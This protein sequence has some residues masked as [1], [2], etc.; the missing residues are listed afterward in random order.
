MNDILFHLVIVGPIVRYLINLGY[1]YTKSKFWGLAL[2]VI[3]LGIIAYYECRRQP[4][5][6]DIL[7]IP[8]H[9]QK[10]ALTKDIKAAFKKISLKTHPDK[11]LDDPLAHD[12]YIIVKNAHEI[13]QNDVHRSNYIRFGDFHGPNDETP[14]SDDN[15]SVVMTVS[16]TQYLTLLIIGLMFSYSKEQMLARQMILL[17]L[18]AVFCLEIQMRFTKNDSTLDW[19][20]MFGD[21]LVFEKIVMFRSVFPSVLNIAMVVSSCLYTDQDSITIQLLQETITSNLKLVKH[22]VD[23]FNIVD[24]RTSAPVQVLD[25]NRGDISLVDA[26]V[27]TTPDNKPNIDWMSLTDTQKS[28]LMRNIGPNLKKEKKGIKWNYIVG[29]LIII[30]AMMYSKMIE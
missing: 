21:F 12:R 29:S 14:L 4:N 18:A 9:Q 19:V 17:Y 28:E 5:L 30:G 11:H 20:P 22:H 1:K 7:E 2:A 15:F 26:S 23:L 6:F 10:N 3:F 27:Q 8:Q 25:Y 16:A 13:L 24:L